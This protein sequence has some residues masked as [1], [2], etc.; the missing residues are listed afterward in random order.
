M[1]LCQND[2]TPKFLCGINGRSLKRN[3]KVRMKIENE[4]WEMNCLRH[5]LRSAISCIALRTLTIVGDALCGVPFLF[6]L[7]KTSQRKTI[8]AALPIRSMKGINPYNCV[9]YISYP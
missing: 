9:V 4:K 1:G 7:C 8:I 6:K 3:E 2:V 5:E